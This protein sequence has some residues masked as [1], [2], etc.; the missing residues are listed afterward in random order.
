MC[1]PLPKWYSVVRRAD[2]SIQRGASPI[3]VIEGTDPPPAMKAVFIH[4]TSDAI[5]LLPSPFLR[6][7]CL[8][9]PRTRVGR[10]PVVSS[11]RNVIKFNFRGKQQPCVP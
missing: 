6:V 3:S 11:T 4:F 7:T 9:Q 10:R 2:P 5:G 1:W 8:Y